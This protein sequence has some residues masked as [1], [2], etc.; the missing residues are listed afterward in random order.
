VGVVHYLKG[1]QPG[2]L[3]WIASA[4]MLLFAFL[5]CMQVVFVHLVRLELSPLGI[6]AVGPLS[7]AQWLSWDEISEATLRERRNPVSRTDHLL[8]LKSPRTMLNY[9]LSVLP[10]PAEAAVLDELRLRTRLVVIQD[11]PAI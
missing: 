4:V 8:I 10:R 6:R 2:V 5:L 3:I 1:P 9:P 11:R 7:G